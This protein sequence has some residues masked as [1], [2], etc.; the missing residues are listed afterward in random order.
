MDMWFGPIIGDMMIY[1]EGLEAVARGSCRAQFLTQAGNSVGMCHESHR[2]TGA[3]Q[4]LLLYC[5]HVVFIHI[6]TK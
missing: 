1:L 6:V 3:K 5:R 4:A 2:I